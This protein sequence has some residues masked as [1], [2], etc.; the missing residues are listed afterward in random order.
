MMCRQNQRRIL[1]CIAVCGLD[2]QQFD[3]RIGQAQADRILAACHNEHTDRM[4]GLAHTAEWIVPESN[5]Y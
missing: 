5:S 1:R 3:Q 2:G 4:L